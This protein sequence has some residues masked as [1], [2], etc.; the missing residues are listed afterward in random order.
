MDIRKDEVVTSG[1]TFWT[2]WAINPIT[3]FPP[4][5]LSI[6]VPAFQ[7]YVFPRMDD[8]EED[9]TNKT[10]G[11]NKGR[12]VIDII[13]AITFRAC[14]LPSNSLTI[15]KASTKSFMSVFSRISLNCMKA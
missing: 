14:L 6:G 12:I 15:S 1:N 13:I 9:K 10:I 2:S 8:E 5:S 3:R 7:Q 4:F 11:F